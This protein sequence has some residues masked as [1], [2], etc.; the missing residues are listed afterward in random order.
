MPA[1]QELGSDIGEIVGPPLLVDIPQTRYLAG[2]I[3]VSEVYALIRAGRLRAVKLG[4]RTF[5]HRSSVEALVAG[6]PEVETS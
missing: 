3:S 1:T 5:I 2:G 4:R 6:L